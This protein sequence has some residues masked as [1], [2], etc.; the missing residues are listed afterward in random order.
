M[1][2]FSQHRLCAVAL[3]RGSRPESDAVICQ[4]PILDLLS[5]IEDALINT[6]RNKSSLSVVNQP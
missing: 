4:E 5:V 1:A 3:R 2:R 6:G